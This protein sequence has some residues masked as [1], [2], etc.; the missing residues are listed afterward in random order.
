LVQRI[1]IVDEIALNRRDDF[2]TGYSSL[3]HLGQ[4][5]Q[6][7]FL[8]ASGCALGQGYLYGRPTPA[9]G[10]DALRKRQ[11]GGATS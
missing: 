9:E 8:R 10:F 3:A 11:T 1:V 4:A 6:A 7:A 2:G 5:T